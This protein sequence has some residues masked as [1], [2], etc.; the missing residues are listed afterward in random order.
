MEKL[1]N[2]RVSVVI[3]C[4]NSENSLDILVSELIKCLGDNLMEI[5]LINDASTDSTWNVIVD[6]SRMSPIVKGIN[7]HENVG[8]HRALLIA[9]WYVQG[10]LIATIDDDL[11]HSPHEI[12]ILLDYVDQNQNIDVVFGVYNTNEKFNLGRWIVN[13]VVTLFSRKNIFIRISSFRVIRKS[14]IEKL[15][16]TSVKN[17]VIG[18]LLLSYSSNIAN[19]YVERK[20]RLFGESNYNWRKHIMLF[21]RILKQYWIH[22]FKNSRSEISINPYIHLVREKVGFKF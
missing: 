7:L 8:Q 21:S 16:T 19:V 12:S 3:P 14:V 5:I 22:F 11:Q 4:Y 13:L 2:Q 20:D 6:L 1:I 18:V 10:E 9:F 15:K 17:P